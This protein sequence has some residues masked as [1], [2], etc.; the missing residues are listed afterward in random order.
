MGYQEFTFKISK[1]PNIYS[2]HNILNIANKVPYV[3]S[4]AYLKP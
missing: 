4:L 2:H 3:H 1:Q